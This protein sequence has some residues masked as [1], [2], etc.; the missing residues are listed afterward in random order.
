MSRDQA[1]NAVKFAVPTVVNGK[2]YIGTSNQVDVYGLLPVVATPVIS[3]SSESFQSSLQINITDATSGAVI[4]YTTDGSTPTQTH[5]DVFKL[6][7]KI[8]RS[9]TVQAIAVAAKYANSAVAS[10]SYTLAP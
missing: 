5:G 8:T 7:F 9:T 1:G 4:H 6:P 10:E 3:P 2:V